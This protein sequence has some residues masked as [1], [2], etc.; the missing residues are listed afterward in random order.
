M[1]A[2]LDAPDRPVAP[3]GRRRLLA[4]GLRLAAGIGALGVG[5]AGL[6]ACAALHPPL[7]VGSS[8]AQAP[9][10]LALY[11]ATG[12]IARV[13]AVT[14]PSQL[15][16][17]QPPVPAQLPD[18][19]D[20]TQQNIWLGAR[21]LSQQG[22]YLQA[23]DGL[24]PAAFPRDVLDAHALRA[25]TLGGS[26]W[27]VPITLAHSEIALS[28]GLAAASG[29]QVPAAGL[30]LSR[31]GQALA[32]ASPRLPPG[33][34]GLELSEV[35]V[36]EWTAIAYGQ[37][38]TLTAGGRFTFAS[39]ASLTALTALGSICRAYG[40]V[41]LFPLGRALL[42]F[43]FGNGNAPA[44]A[45]ATH[46]PMGLLP[47]L[48]LPRPVSPALTIGCAATRRARPHSSLGSPGRPRSSGSSPTA[49]RRRA[50]TWRPT[51]AGCPRC[52]PA[53]RR[54]PCCAPRPR[55]CCRRP[56]GT[57]RSSRPS[58]RRP[59]PPSRPAWAPPSPSP[60]RPARTPPTACSPRCN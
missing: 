56:S 16:G 5:G 39:G 52:P 17:G 7:S 36:P 8:L 2:T 22:P 6:S 57:P 9:A 45:Q 3:Y 55:W 46:S 49:P 50:R 30:D 47:F 48:Q 21:G 58:G 35:G 14:P 32:E 25:L 37:G 15:A 12:P 18:I 43:T 59:S 38:G 53:T 28:I 54:P 42:S 51:G 24:L 44:Y 1:P 40:G 13:K 11:N 23:L 4:A 29:F 33:S 10:L 27:G 19:V 20:V 60:S 26:L 41:N 34:A 31:L